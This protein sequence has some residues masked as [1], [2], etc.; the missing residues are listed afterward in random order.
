MDQHGEALIRLA[1]MYVKAWQAAEDIL[2]EVFI[3]YYQKRD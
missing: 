2:Q 1:Y 3:T